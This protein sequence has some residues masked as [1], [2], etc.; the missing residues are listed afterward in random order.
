MN[1][2]DQKKG[3]KRSFPLNIELNFCKK[4]KRFTLTLFS[5]NSINHQEKK[6]NCATVW[7]VYEA[8]TIFHAKSFSRE[9][10]RNQLFALKSFFSPSK[11]QVWWHKRVNRIEETRLSLVEP[12]SKSLNFH[13]ALS[14][15]EKE[16]W[17]K[18]YIRNHAIHQLRSS[19]GWFRDKSEMKKRKNRI[20]WTIEM[21]WL[22]LRNRPITL[23]WCNFSLF[24]CSW[25]PNPFSM[26]FIRID[27][28]SKIFWAGK[29]KQRALVH[30][31]M[32]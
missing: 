9:N 29:S 11:T 27:L 14:A 30:S 8:K 10:S 16:E 26:C 32:L 3:E 28:R 4:L 19:F 22:N 18:I 15:K 23:K 7:K 2:H 21:W 12:S 31:K 17:E 20:S 24:F 6:K 5:G 13:S 1:F 25:K